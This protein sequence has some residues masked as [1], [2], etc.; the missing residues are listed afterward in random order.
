MDHKSKK[1][2]YSGEKK[3]MYWKKEKIG[4]DAREQALRVEISSLSLSTSTTSLT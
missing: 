1:G 4:M 3:N 2:K